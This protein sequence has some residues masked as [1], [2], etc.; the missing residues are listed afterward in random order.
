MSSADRSYP[1]SSLQDVRA[2]LQENL[3]MHIN[4]NIAFLACIAS[5]ITQESRERLRVHLREVL[6]VTSAMI[7]SGT[8]KHVPLSTSQA[9]WYEIAH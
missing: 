5:F 4:C 1:D 9:A 2:S 8:R 6:R 7:V 3:H